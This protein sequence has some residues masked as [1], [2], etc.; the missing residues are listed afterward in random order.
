M[1]FTCNIYPSKGEK[2]ERIKL[3]SGER[4]KDVRKDAFFSTTRSGKRIQIKRRLEKSVGTGGEYDASGIA[5]RQLW[6]IHSSQESGFSII[7]EDVSAVTLLL[8]TQRLRSLNAFL[9]M[10]DRHDTQSLLKSSLTANSNFTSEK[11]E[12]VY[13]ISVVTD[14]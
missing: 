3:P 1:T 11:N 9:T 12:S 2:D 4:K 7:P 8:T 13:R 5:M 10:A 6:K 14:N